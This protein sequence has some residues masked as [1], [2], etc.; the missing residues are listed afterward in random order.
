[1]THLTDA[2]MLKRVTRHLKE[3]MDLVNGEESERRKEEVW[4]DL[5]KRIGAS[6]LEGEL[7]RGERVE[8]LR[9]MGKLGS[10]TDSI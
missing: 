10:H 8:K 6:G 9:R 4:R 3:A 2:K 1:M 5:W 7:E